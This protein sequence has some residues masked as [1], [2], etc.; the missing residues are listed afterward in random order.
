MNFNHKNI[1]SSQQYLREFY[2]ILDKMEKAMTEAEITDSISTTFINQMI[3]HHRAAIEMSESIL[4]YSNDKDIRKI[5]ENI[6][7]EQTGSI[8]NME[9]AYCK[10]SDC[11]NSCDDME[12]Y[13]NKFAYI[14]DEMFSGMR[15]SADSENVNYDFLTEMLPHHMGA[16]R[17]SKNALNFRLCEPLKPILDAIIVSQCRGI[18]QMQRLLEQYK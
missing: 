4:K 6:I 2:R 8:E 12:K 9:K 14:T 10:C 17:M 7:A 13:L 1:C 18:E 5:A 15:N 3:P 11:R 16:V